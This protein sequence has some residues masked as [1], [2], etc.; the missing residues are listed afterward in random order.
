M[1]S[2]NKKIKVILNIKDTLPLDYLELNSEIIIKNQGDL[3]K[4]KIVDILNQKF[5]NVFIFLT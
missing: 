5:K 2:Y 4:G 3:I 1:C